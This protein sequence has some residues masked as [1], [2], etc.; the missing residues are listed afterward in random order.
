MTP[1]RK[2]RRPLAALVLAAPLLAP[3]LPSRPAQAQEEIGG[4]KRERIAI[5]W[6]EHK[7]KSFL[8]L[9]ESVI[10][11]AVVRR[12]A[13][14]LEDA[15]SQYVAVFGFKPEKPLQA[16]MLD[17]QN[18]YE[19][20]GGDLSHPGH[21]N[22]GTGFLVLLQKEFYQL[23]PTAYHEAFHQYLHEYIGGD[24]PIPTWFNEGMAMYFEGMQVNK[25]TKKID[26]RLIDNRK[27]GMVQRAILTRTSI[28][29]EKLIDASYEEFHDKKKESLHYTQSLAVIYFFMKSARKSLFD[30]A[31][32]LQETKDLALANEKV[33]GKERKKMGSIEKQWKAF[34]AS[35]KIG[36]VAK[37]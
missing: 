35:L 1:D 25:Q 33:F 7:T 11:G 17:S 36:E 15:L 30:Y 29:F 13:D 27:I 34:T 20:E 3:L 23:I 16:K 12:V 8:F 2:L 28:P 6:K 9:Y 4:K 19:Q 37:S 18:T 14:A 32:T 24:V 5:E 21:F 10:P 22:R 31:K 26:Y